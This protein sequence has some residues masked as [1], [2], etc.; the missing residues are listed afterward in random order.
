MQKLIIFILKPKTGYEEGDGKFIV[1]DYIFYESGPQKSLKTIDESP[2][3][4][5]ISGL[6][7]SSN[8][9]F[10]MSL[11]LLQQWVFGNLEGF[12]QSR[13]YEAASIV[14]I[15]VAGRSII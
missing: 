3:V 2:L 15:I 14:R 13:D 1:E 9:N 6:N 10:S 5:F 7:Q 4:V 8:N 11:E 12:G